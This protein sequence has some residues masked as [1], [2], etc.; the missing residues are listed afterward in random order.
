MAEPRE[1]REYLVGMVLSALEEVC[2]YSVVAGSSGFLLLERAGDP[3]ALPLIL[4]VSRNVISSTIL[5]AQLEAIGERVEPVFARL[6][7]M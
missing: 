4:D 1:E 3:T 7:S 5:Q 6:E 2:R